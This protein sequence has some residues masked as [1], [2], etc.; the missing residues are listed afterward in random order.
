MRGSASTSSEVIAKAL[1]LQQSGH[2][3]EASR[4]YEAV[5]RR[6]PSNCDVLRLLAV[7]LAEQGKLETAAHLMQRALKHDPLSPESA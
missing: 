3:R 5:L 4:L 7:A 2:L 6:D 1:C